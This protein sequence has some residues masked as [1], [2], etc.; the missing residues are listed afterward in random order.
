M[1]MPNNDDVEITIT[2]RHNTVKKKYNVDSILP[3]RCRRN[4][5][6]LFHGFHNLL[7]DKKAPRVEIIRSYAIKFT[8]NINVNISV[9]WC[10]LN[11]CS[12]SKKRCACANIIWHTANTHSSRHLYMITCYIN[13]GT[14]DVN[15]NDTETLLE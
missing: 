10:F 6:S 1:Y 2:W 14:L 3:I 13:T 12:D 4:Q 7:T 5:P 8:C 9:N 15:K 11:L